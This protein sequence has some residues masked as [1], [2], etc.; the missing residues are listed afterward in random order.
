MLIFMSSE[1]EKNKTMRY[2]ARNNF[3]EKNARLESLDLKIT[4]IMIDR[5]SIRMDSSLLAK[6]RNTYCNT[7]KRMYGKITLLCHSSDI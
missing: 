1:L 4:N 2:E 6:Q 5:D 7:T 3:E